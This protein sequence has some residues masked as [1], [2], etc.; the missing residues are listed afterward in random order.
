MT[1]RWKTTRG[2][3]KPGMAGPRSAGRLQ[4]AIDDLVRREIVAALR[5][6]D[7]NVTH[8]AKAL[9]ISRIALRARMNVLDVDV[10]RRG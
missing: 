4:R 6:T 3:R 2:K 8:A 7:G 5:E 10:P 9:G 1:A